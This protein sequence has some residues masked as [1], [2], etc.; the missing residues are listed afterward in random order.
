[1]EQREAT[2]KNNTFGEKLKPLK[3]KV[4]L[5]VLG[6]ELFSVAFSK[7]KAERIALNDI[8]EKAAKPNMVAFPSEEIE[9]N[10]QEENEIEM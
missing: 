10:K 5:M 2:V 1:M 7:K 8:R 4:A 3:K 9:E 6:M